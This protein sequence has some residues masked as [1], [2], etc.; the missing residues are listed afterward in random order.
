M[1]LFFVVGFT[2]L[3]GYS[4]SKA[5]EPAIQAKN[6]AITATGNNTDGVLIAQNANRKVRHNIKATDILELLVKG[7]I[8]VDMDSLMFINETNDPEKLFGQPGQAIEKI[9]FTDTRHPEKAH[10]CY[11]IVFANSSE[12]QADTELMNELE[13]T[14]GYPETTSFSYGVVTVRLPLAV[15]ISDYD[16]YM[17]VFY[18]L[19]PAQVGEELL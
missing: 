6:N 14:D 4:G 19:A 1:I 12:M 5:A 3:T 9:A 11:V 10:Q 8:P 17:D 18:G 13:D 15:G 16:E 7:G 2:I